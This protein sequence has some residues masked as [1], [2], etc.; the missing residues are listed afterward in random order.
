MLDSDLY[1]TDTFLWSILTIFYIDTPLGCDL[2]ALGME[3]GAISDSQISASSEYSQNLAAIFGRLNGQEFGR[4]GWAPRV[5]DSYQWLQID[6]RNQDTSVMRV[7]T[8]GRAYS[9]QWVTSY[10]LQYCNDIDN[11]HS[12]KAQGQSNA[13]VK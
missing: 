7:A 9:P 13:K 3:N 10:K 12:Y 1:G 2:K 6:L 5:L 11:L 8:Q 4:D